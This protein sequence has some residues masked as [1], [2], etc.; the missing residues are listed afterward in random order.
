MKINKKN[1]IIPSL[2][3]TISAALVGSIAGTVAW[4]QYNTRVSASYYG[5]SAGSATENLQLSLD[6]DNWSTELKAADIQAYLNQHG[7]IGS[8]LRPVTTGAQAKDGD[9]GT[10]YKNPIY[11]HAKTST[12]GLAN[13]EEDY[14]TFP[15]SLR[16]KDIDGGQ[17]T[18][19]FVGL[20]KKVYLQNVVLKGSNTNDITDAMRLHVAG[21]D[22][23]VLLSEDLLSTKALMFPCVMIL[24]LL[25]TSKN[26]SVISFSLTLASF[27]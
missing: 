23:S 10:L 5:T 11:Q 21:H 24:N 3:T 19:N 26:K 2:L 17:D 16:V 7:H 22:N 9:L 12:W 6:G 14:I 25:V 20:E 27:I 1:V 18:T 13:D 4:Y 15:I 8:Q